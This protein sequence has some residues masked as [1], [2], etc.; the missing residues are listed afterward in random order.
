MSAGRALV[1]LAVA[2]AGLPPPA[3]AEQRP[4]WEFGLGVTGLYLPDYRGANQ[5]RGYVFPLPYAAYRGERFKVDREGIRGIFFDTD[6]VELDVS[7][8]GT[9][10]VKSSKN[11]AR[12]GMPDLDATLEV[13]PVLEIT[14]ARDRKIDYNYR[15]QLRL[16]ARAVFP[17]DV[18]HWSYAGWTFYPNLSL[19]LRPEFLGGRWN[20]GFA[21]GPLYASQKYNAYF[22]S[23]APQF[24]TPDRPAYQAPGGYSGWVGFATLSRR[25]GKVWVGAYVRYDTLSGA[26]FEAS[27][28]VKRDYAWSTGI[29]IAWVF[30]QS[31][32]LVETED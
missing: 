6:R 24:A 26:T 16:P 25:F 1:V 10:P 11:E 23:V 15:L 30:A 21:A 14:L 9:P 12:Q 17:T 27:P 13:G 32:T 2:A 29:G 28:L 31:T 8:F 7:V 19:D 20:V 4:L 5:G 3:G 18:V 22:Y